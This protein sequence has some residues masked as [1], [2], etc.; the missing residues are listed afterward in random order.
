MNGF[1][2]WI[3]W[4]APAESR[5]EC[6]ERMLA[7]SEPAEPE[8]QTTRLAGRAALGASAPEAAPSILELDG[9]WVAI[10]GEIRLA[11][12]AGA[13]RGRAVE[14]RDVLAAYRERGERALESWGGG[15]AL[16]IVA[17]DG[18]EALLA[19]DRIGGRFPLSYRVANGALVFAT[20]AQAI[21]VHPRG[22]APIDPQGVYD[23]LYFHVI[24][25][26]RSIR[27]GV[28]RLRP[29]GYAAWRNGALREGIHWRPA[30]RDDDR[31]SLPNLCEEFRTV[32][33]RSVELHAGGA[34]VGC[35]LSGGTDSS[36]IAGYLG[37]LTGSP[38]RTYSIGFDA[39]GF[40][41]MSYAR[42][43]AAA[44]GTEHHEYYVTPADVLEAV[45]RVARAYA[46]PFGNASAVP[47]Y[48]CAK[49]ARRDGIERLL[50]GD[51]GD[52]LF[53]GNS[54][55]ATQKL[56]G[57]Y[58]RIPSLGR[59]VLERS[60]ALLPGALPPI[61]KVRSYIAQASLPMP[62]RLHTY[63]MFERDGAQR[64]VDPDLL[65]SIDAAEPM[66]LQVELYRAARAETLLNRMLA[67][68]L[69]FTLADNDLPKVSRMCQM[70]GVD[71]A[72]PFLDD[73]MVEFS[74]RVPARLK[75]KGL[76]LRWFFKHALR[77]FLPQAILQKSKHGFGLP[78]GLW[79]RDDRALQEFA[80]ANLAALKRRNLV[81]AEYIDETTRLHASDHAT[82]YGG[83]IWMLVMLEQWFEQHEERAGGGG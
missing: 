44:F 6:L 72:Y 33:R 69:E 32:L 60:V 7:Q 64:I 42:T 35:F 15:F 1:C 58:E 18:S 51:G 66:N 14:A 11:P 28:R 41:E 2:G 37:P 57:L 68:D 65:R 20:A 9:F 16:A 76:K 56:L 39:Q 63:N 8:V 29:A 34:A 23:Y 70:A 77:D 3:G 10:Q 67:L 26:P 75:L 53:G 71:V 25:L 19:I 80:R 30:Y 21:Q 36:S 49:E 13:E 78:F 50:G 73:E 40:D 17:R 74:L 4:E 62:Q 24:P 48:Y 5:R 12:Q 61:R 54:R 79:M 82:Y 81:R 47:A 45:P 52:E 46:E 83:T 43:A 38:A 55:Y 22:R 27:A 59:R 31:V